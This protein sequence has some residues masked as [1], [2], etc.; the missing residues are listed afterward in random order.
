MS[1]ADAHAVK[2]GWKEK[3]GVRLLFGRWQDVLPQLETY[4]GVFFDTYG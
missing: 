2:L 1:V 4:D 3:P